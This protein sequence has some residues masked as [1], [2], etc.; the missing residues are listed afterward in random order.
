MR[1]KI[2]F[3]QNEDTEQP[4]VQQSITLAGLGRLSSNSYNEVTTTLQNVAYFQSD[5]PQMGDDVPLDYRRGVDEN[6]LFEAAENARERISKKRSDA[7]RERE[8]QNRRET[9]VV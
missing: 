3:F 9:Q 1:N 5:R 4:V 8:E 6:D 2:L 7:K